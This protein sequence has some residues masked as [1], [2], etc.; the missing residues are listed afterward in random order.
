MQR[1]I[2][3]FALVVV[4]GGCSAGGTSARPVASPAASA[5][6]EVMGQG[7]LQPV[8]GTASGVAE[9]VVLPAGT[10][11]VVLESF[12]IESSA[13]T[14]VVLVKNEAVTATADVDKSMLLDLGPLKG[15]SGMQ[16]LAI[17]ASMSATVGQD[18]H[19]VVIWDTEMAHAIAAASLQ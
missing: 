8:D 14:N 4:I 16:T 5:T 6:L 11:E 3:G 18:Y 12:Q 1:A 19:S 10:Y 15:T 9:L 17:P 7:Q 2:V 13:H